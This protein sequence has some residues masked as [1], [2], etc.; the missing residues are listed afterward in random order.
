MFSGIAH[1]NDCREKMYYCTSRHFEARQDY[2]VCST[3]R[4][5]GADNCPSHFVRAVILEQGVLA[6]MRL[7]ISCVSNHEERFRQAMGAK[8]KA[9]TKRELAQKRKQYTQAERRIG[10][11]DRLFKRIYE[12]FAN[13]KL[14]ESRF[15]MLSDDY[16]AEQE[17]L[18]EKL[19]LLEEEITQQEEQANNLERFIGKVKKYLDL[20]ELTPAV[21]NDMVKAVYVHTVVKEDGVRVQDVDIS[22]DLVGILPA[23]LL[24]G[25]QN[26]ES[27]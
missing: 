19:L 23:S 12:D 16:E 21:L 10:E 24:Y 11:L 9:D 22:Y 7:V 3:S 26:D 14:S 18:R 25:L 1:C 27:A 2:F 6:H 15:Q 17:N 5:Q 20:Q 13:E 8:H 4:K